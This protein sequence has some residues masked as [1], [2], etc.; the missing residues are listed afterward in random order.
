MAKLLAEFATAK[1]KK[2]DLQ[3]QF[4]AKMAAMR[5]SGV[6]GQGWGEGGFVFSFLGFAMHTCTILVVRTY[7]GFLGRS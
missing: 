3:Q 4:E 6:G 7:V 2:D 1:Q 5:R